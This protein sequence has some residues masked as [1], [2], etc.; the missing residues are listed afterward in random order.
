MPNNN[1]LNKPKPLAYY[2]DEGIWTDDP[3]PADFNTVIILM[4]ASGSMLKLIQDMEDRL[5]PDVYARL[6]CQTY[7]LF[8]AIG[9]YQDIWSGEADPVYYSSDV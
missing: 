1:P 4:W 3:T 2:E 7:S 8:S 6:F 9:Q 5:S